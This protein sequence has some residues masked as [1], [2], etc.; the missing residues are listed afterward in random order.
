MCVC[1][2]VQICALFFLLQHQWWSPV[3]SDL[4]FELRRASVWFN[5]KFEES[6]LCS[7]IRTEGDYCNDLR[8]SLGVCMG[9]GVVPRWVKVQQPQTH[10]V[11]RSFTGQTSAQGAACPDLI[12]DI[13]G[14]PSEN[15]WKKNIELILVKIEGLAVHTHTHRH[16][17]IHTHIYIYRHTPFRTCVT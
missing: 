1:V 11:R 15:W 6:L 14:D 9:R 10:E 8:G 5:R 3:C 16:A 13:F 12:S 2:A 7:Q 17:G 4:L